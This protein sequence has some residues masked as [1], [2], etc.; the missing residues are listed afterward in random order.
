[1]D[2]DAKVIS[3]D[4]VVSFDDPDPTETVRKIRE[5]AE[6]ANEGYVVI[7]QY[8]QDFSLSE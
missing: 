3:F 2:N 6:K 4:L 7:A 8:D 1:M 5:E